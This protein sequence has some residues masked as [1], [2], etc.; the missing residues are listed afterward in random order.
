[1]RTTVTIDPDTEAMLKEEVRRTGQSFKRILNESIRKALGRNETAKNA[2][3]VP[4]FREPFPPGLP[5]K[6]L[7]RLADE[8]DD[9]ETLRELG[10]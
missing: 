1:M 9:E 2:A 10:K 8:L 4:L 3:V 5:E 6:S 7:N